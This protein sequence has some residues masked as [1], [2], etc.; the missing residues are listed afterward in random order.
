MG[1]V[2]FRQAERRSGTKNEGSGEEA[3]GTEQDVRGRDD[4]EKKGQDEVVP[5]ARKEVREGG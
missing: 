5:E 3:A 4:Q 1:R 2:A